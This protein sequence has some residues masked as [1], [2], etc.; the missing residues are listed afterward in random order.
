MEIEGGR[1]APAKRLTSLESFTS[2]FLRPTWLY[3]DEIPSMIQMMEATAEA[4]VCGPRS[5]IYFNKH[6]MCWPFC[7]GAEPNSATEGR[8]IH[9]LGFSGVTLTTVVEPYN[10]KREEKCLHSLDT[11]SHVKLLQ[12]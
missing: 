8:C 10:E 5:P 2:S 7:I 11:S 4:H 12:P 3:C 9:R 1:P 6:W